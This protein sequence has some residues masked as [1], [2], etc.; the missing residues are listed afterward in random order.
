MGWKRMAIKG[1]MF[2]APDR[3]LFRDWMNANRPA[4]YWA[5]CNMDLGP[6]DFELIDNEMHLGREAYVSVC[7]FMA[8]RGVDVPLR[9]M[10]KAQTN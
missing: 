4:S 2:V 3:E 10:S 8:T 7:T 9:T 1:N 6:W 5:L